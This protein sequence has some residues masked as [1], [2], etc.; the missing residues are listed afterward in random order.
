MSGLKLSRKP[1]HQNA[2]VAGLMT[3]RELCDI[4]I[5]LDADLQDD[6]EVLDQFVE[7]IIKGRRSFTVCAAPGIRDT[8]FKTLHRHGFYGLM[9]K[10]GSILSGNHADYRLMSKKA[11]DCFSGYHGS[12]PV[13]RGSCR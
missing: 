11:L 4:T 2:L 9:K 5:S 12:E 6:I 10:M 3:A 7:G 8:A 13:L 1:G